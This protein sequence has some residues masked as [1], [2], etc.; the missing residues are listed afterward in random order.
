MIE[1]QG[2][3]QMKALEEHWKQLIK[4][5]IEKDFLEHLKQKNFLMSL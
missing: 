1:N 3:K 5:S 2:K 4:S